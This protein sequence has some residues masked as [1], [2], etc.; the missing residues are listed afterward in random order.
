MTTESKPSAVVL[1]TY[2]GL[3]EDQTLTQFVAE[4]KQLSDEEKQQLADGITDGT[5]TY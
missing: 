3:K 4:L 1:K 5:L 2:F